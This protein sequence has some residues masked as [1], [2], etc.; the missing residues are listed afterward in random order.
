MEPRTP[1]EPQKYR[2][3]ASLGFPGRPLSQRNK[4]KL[5]C[6][7]RADPDI[8]QSLKL[9]SLGSSNFTQLQVS[10]AIHLAEGE[11]V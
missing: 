9:G 8:V 2:F 10:S 3:E 6:G 11:E 5:K 1:Q 7:K 4:T